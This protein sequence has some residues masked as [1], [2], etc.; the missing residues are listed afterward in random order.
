ML[1]A[2]RLGDLAELLRGVPAQRGLLQQPR[3]QRL[4]AARV[5]RTGLG[6]EQPAGEAVGVLGA[7]AGQREHRPR[8]LAQQLGRA[9]AELG[10]RRRGELRGRAAGRQHLGDR[11]QRGPALG[12]GGR[13]VGAR[14]GG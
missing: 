10:D 13:A 6:A 11:V 3:H 12:V 5:A 1:G 7:D 2:Q 4:G 8:V 14:R 9:L